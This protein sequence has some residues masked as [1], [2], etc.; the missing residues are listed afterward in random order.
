MTGR[1]IRIIEHKPEKSFS[2]RLEDRA[3]AL[4]KN[5][6]NRDTSDPVVKIVE[7][8]L[9]LAM[10]HIRS[11]RRVHEQLR[12]DLTRV[13]CYIETEIIQRGPRIPVYVDR[14]I[15]E[16]DMLRARLLTIGQERRRLA[17]AETEKMQAL[18]DRLQMLMNRSMSLGDH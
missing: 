1:R 8:D 12:R 7:R 11:V 10:S 16:R 15:G 2:E 6:R 14:R 17:L 3:G 18:H 5:A 13:E 4:L 9:A